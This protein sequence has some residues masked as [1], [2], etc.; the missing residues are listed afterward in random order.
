[1]SISLMVSFGASLPFSFAYKLCN[2]L[3]LSIFVFCRKKRNKVTVMLMFD[4]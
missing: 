4:L 3:V 1:M 2:C